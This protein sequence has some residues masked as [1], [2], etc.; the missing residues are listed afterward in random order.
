MNSIGNALRRLRDVADVD[1]SAE[2]IVDALRHGGCAVRGAEI[3]CNKLRA[4]D[5]IGKETQKEVLL[6]MRNQPREKAR[7]PAQEPRL[8]VVA[9]MV[10]GKPDLIYG[11][12]ARTRPEAWTLAVYAYTGS[13]GTAAMQRTLH[14]KGYRAVRVNLELYM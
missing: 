7:V 9:R 6:A 3:V 13:H 14:R 12:L 1:M 10:D 5:R 2:R 4:D 11:T 8:Y